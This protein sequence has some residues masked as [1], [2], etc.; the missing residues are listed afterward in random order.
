MSFHRGFSAK[1]RRGRPRGPNRKTILRREIEVV[2]LYR[3]EGIRPGSDPALVNQNLRII[4]KHAPH[5]LQAG[6]AKPSWEPD[7]PLPL[8]VCVTVAFFSVILAVCLGLVFAYVIKSRFETRERAYKLFPPLAE[9][10]PKVGESPT[11]AK[12]TPNSEIASISYRVSMACESE[13]HLLCVEEYIN[14]SFVCS[15]SCHKLT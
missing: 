4:R 6:R 5:L 8:V 1:M 14:P 13:K 15:C 11:V 9:S 12:S 7:I 10:G 3:S 2:N